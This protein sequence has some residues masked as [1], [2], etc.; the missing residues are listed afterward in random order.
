MD[1][2]CFQQSPPTLTASGC[3]RFRRLIPCSESANKTICRKSKQ[4]P[5]ELT[6]IGW[7]PQGYSFPPTTLMHKPQRNARLIGLEIAV[8]FTETCDEDRPHL[9]THVV[10]DIGPIPDRD[11]L[12]EIH[13][14][15]QRQELLPHHHLVDAG[16][17][18]AE[19]LLASQ[20]EYHVDLVGPTAQDHRWQARE[21]KGYALPDFFI[22][23][24]HKQA[25]CPQGQ[26][27]S[28]WTPK[29]HAESGSHQ[30]QVWLC[31]LWSLR[32]RGPSAPNPGSVPLPFAGAKHML[33]WRLLAN[34]SRQ[35]NLLSC[36]RSRA[37]IE[38]AHGKASAANGTAPVALHWRATHT[39]ATCG[40]CCCHQL[41][42]II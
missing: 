14:A 2:D 24:E 27:S 39:L 26:I 8:H 35:K 9:I 31:Y 40:N 4:E 13:A 28:S 33:P 42:S 34:V 22:D 12:P 25:R 18:D 21:Q 1:G 36:M 37:G 30:D 6:R 19:A 3:S 11:E 7:R 41:V 29:R 32:S 38:G 17:V 16:Y 15:L 10:T 5:G 23:W 20:T